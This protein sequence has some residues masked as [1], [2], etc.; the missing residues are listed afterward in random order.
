MAKRIVFCLA[1]VMLVAGG[2][3][4]QS[5]SQNAASL[6]LIPLFEGFIVSDNDTDT[7]LFCL[8]LAYERLIAP[9]LSVGADVDLFLGEVFDVSYFYFG[10]AATGR[11]YVMSEQMEKLFIGARLGFDLQAIDGETD[12]EDGGFFGFQIGVSVGWRQMFG[13]MFFVEPSIS[14]NYSKIY[15]NPIMATGGTSDWNGGLCLGVLF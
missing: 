8:A 11:V 9:R 10:V 2:V 1:L 14:Y 5:G 7:S 12:T 4:A 15:A 6:D 13:E 3:F